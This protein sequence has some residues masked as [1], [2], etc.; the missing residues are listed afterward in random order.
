MSESP[1]AH[2][3][4]PTT[5]W[6]LVLAAGSDP[7]RAI[8]ALDQLCRTYWPPLYACAR[9]WGA[10][11]Q[12]APDLVQGFL[13][14]FIAR[15]DLIR[16]SPEKGRF[17]SYLLG[18]FRNYLVSEARRGQAA[19]RG[20]GLAIL[21]LEEAQNEESWRAHAAAGMGPEEA[22]DRRWAEEV[23]RLAL[24]RVQ[25]DYE[26]SGKEKTYA[27]LLPG[28]TSG[29]DD[30]EQIGAQLGVS[31]GAA[32]SAMHRLRGKLREALRSEI[33]KTVA[34]TEDLEDEMRY[35]LSLLIL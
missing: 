24:G 28:L 35:L 25:E 22:Y 5:A 34:S 16:S 15:G 18:A 11:P 4:F 14:G 30:Y 6:T 31:V 13:S 17:R 32:R 1:S 21:S 3:S 8:P 19:K 23:L 26:R 27:T 9:C 29:A 20:G 12:E 2:S 7:A 33:Q 10:A